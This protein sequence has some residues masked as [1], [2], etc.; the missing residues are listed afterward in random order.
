MKSTLYTLLGLLSTRIRG[1]TV[2]ANVSSRRPVVRCDRRHSHPRARLTVVALCSPKHSWATARIVPCDL[3][4]DT[5]REQSF[6]HS[7]MVS[8][9]NNS[10][11][12]S[13][14]IC[15]C[16]PSIAATTEV[17][18]RGAARTKSGWRRS[19]ETAALLRRRSIGA[20]A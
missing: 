9:P 8:A 18:E 2:L 6:H 16:C 20:E 1:W 7:A 10:T 15:G 19:A 3:V 11:S 12:G 13:P 14:Y 4:G 17:N 5:F